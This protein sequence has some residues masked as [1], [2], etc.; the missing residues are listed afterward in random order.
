MKIFKI[1]RILLCFC[2]IMFGMLLQKLVANTLKKTISTYCL[3]NIYIYYNDFF[4]YDIYFS[5]YIINSHRISSMTSISC[6]AL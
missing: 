3:D 5:L 2:R 4:I 6:I 1:N